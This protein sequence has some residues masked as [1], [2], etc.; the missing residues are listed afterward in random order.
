MLGLLLR[1]RRHIRIVLLGILPARV[2]MRLL[3]R[4]E[5]LRR[6][7][8]ESVGIDVDRRLRRGPIHVA[9]V[10]LLSARLFVIW[11]L[12]ARAHVVVIHGGRRPE[13]QEQ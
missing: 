11:D 10:L 2:L 5:G 4:I 8:V 13:K 1:H 3:M 12:V 7:R 6:A 9:V